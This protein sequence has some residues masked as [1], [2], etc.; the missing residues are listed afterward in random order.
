MN[1]EDRLVAVFVALVSRFLTA[2]PSW[3]GNKLATS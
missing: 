3:T 2:R 1:A